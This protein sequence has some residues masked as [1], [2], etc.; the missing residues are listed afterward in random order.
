VDTATSTDDRILITAA[1]GGASLLIWGGTAVSP[2]R[3]FVNV[4]NPN[5]PVLGTIE[6]SFVDRAVGYGSD[7]VIVVGSTATRY[8]GV[9]TV[10]VAGPK[11]ASRT[12]DATTAIW[13]N[14]SGSSII[15]ARPGAL[16]FLSDL[17]EKRC[18]LNF[19]SKASCSL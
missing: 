4:S 9:G 7:F 14:A 12:L 17:N 13:A 10:F 3:T 2:R 1:T 5:A 8:S 19:W 16:Y 18:I 11:I 15:E 6:S